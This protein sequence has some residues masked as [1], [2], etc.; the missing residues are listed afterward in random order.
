M[1]LP[2][3]D[4]VVHA[5][6]HFRLAGD[7]APYFRTNVDG[8]RALLSAARAAG[9]GSFVSI[10]AAAVVMDDA[11]S[12]LVGV[13]E[14]APVHPDSRMPYVASK[15]RAEALVLQAD[16]PGFRTLAL[17]PP[18]IW[19]K[20]DAFSAAL[21]RML[22]R[23][24]FGFID[25]GRYPY[26]TIHADNVVEAVL[27][28]LRTKARGAYFINDTEATTFRDFV[29]GIARALGLE[30][31][32]APSMPYG[33]AH[34]IGAVLERLWSLAG[35]GADPPM[36]RSMVRLIGRAF[37]TSDARARRD[38]GYR[39]MRSRAEGLATYR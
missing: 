25:G 29:I 36:S 23:R 19:G 22:R 11:G 34:G 24:Q 6:A 28:A 31:S 20:G 17:R 27:C 15:A 32:R 16:A 14:T 10:S 2:P 5:A 8:T 26:V 12:P 18:G 4:A 21:P 39:G 35:A 13:D 38:L 3:V 33:V 7:T 30:A 37:V 9:A 1:D